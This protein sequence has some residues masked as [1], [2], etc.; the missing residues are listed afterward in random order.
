MTGIRLNNHGWIVVRIGSL[1]EKSDW[2]P[3]QWFTAGRGMLI[4]FS[5]MWWVT[6][7]AEF[8]DEPP[9]LFQPS[10]STPD[11]ISVFLHWPL[12]LMSQHSG[13]LLIAQ[14][15]GKSMPIYFPRTTVLHA[16]RTKTQKCVNAQ[17][18]ECVCVQFKHSEVNVISLLSHRGRERVKRSDEGVGH[19]AE[20]KCGGHP[21]F[22]QWLI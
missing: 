16:N 8:R 21:S 6:E 12:C 18:S 22:S 9:I 2:N 15:W 17:W 4:H 14:T 10:T 20:G 7:S 5:G 13:K 1:T 11:Q 19:R 3:W